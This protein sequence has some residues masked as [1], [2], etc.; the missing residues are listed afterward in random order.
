MDWRRLGGLFIAVLGTGNLIAQPLRALRDPRDTDYASFVS[1]ARILAAGSRNLYSLAAQH[2][3]ESA[4]LGFTPSPSV[5]NAFLNPAPAA[6]VLIPLTGLPRAVGLGIFL[7]A[8]LTCTVTA[9]TLIY[10]RIVDVVSPQRM[11]LVLTIVTAASFPAGMTLALGQWDPFIFLA[12]TVAIVLLATKR[13]SIVA[14]MLLSVVLLKP[15]LGYLIPVA[16]IAS[17]SWR[18]LWGMAGGAA[19]WAAA[20]WLILGEHV[21]DW[22][23]LIVGN[24]S[25]TTIQTLGLP[26]FAGMIA[27]S[28]QASVVAWAVLSFG[29]AA[30]AV[31]WRTRLRSDRAAAVVLGIAASLLISPHL[32]SDD[33]LLLALPLAWWAR[34][35]P[36]AA[37]CAALALSAAWGVDVAIGPLTGP[38]LETLVMVVVIAGLTA[39]WLRAPYDAAFRSLG[40]AR[41]VAP[42]AA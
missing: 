34:T 11:R 3:A 17:A 6:F 23:R 30:L 9:A 36:R 41:G 32:W 19:M 26:G 39:S 31:R 12:E 5:A 29:A 16:L 10:R 8:T 33:L 7:A 38:H 1:A 22:P 37:L 21:L 40:H 25:A 18:V 2:A 20:S 35:Q 15:Q 28:A 42:R 13:S 4:Y 24:D 14:G 27:R